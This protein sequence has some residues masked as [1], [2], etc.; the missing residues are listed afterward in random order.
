MRH[1]VGTPAKRRYGH[2]AADDFT[3]CGDVGLNAIHTLRAVQSDTK[4]RHHFVDN[5]NRTVFRAQLAQGLHE[6]G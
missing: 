5:Q 1:D 2:T 4:A 6:F 3:E